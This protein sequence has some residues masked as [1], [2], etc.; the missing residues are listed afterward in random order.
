MSS[1]PENKPTLDRSTLLPILLGVFSLFGILLVFAIGRL[2]SGGN[3][4]PPEDT[5][6][7]FKYQLIGTEPGVSTAELTGEPGSSA[8]PLDG[9]EVPS[10]GS[11]GLVVTAQQGSSS[12]SGSSTNDNSAGTQDPSADEFEETATLTPTDPIIILRTNTKSN[13]TSLPIINRTQ[14]P[15]NTRGPTWTVT[16]S[17][18]K[19]VGPTT[20]EI[21]TIT[22]S[23]TP[24]RTP[25]SIPTGA[26]A[27][28][29]AA[30][31]YDDS[32]PLISY[33]GWTIIT[34][35]SAYQS[36]L[37]VSNTAGSTVI[38][39]FTGQQIRLTFQSSASFGTIRINIGGLNFDLDEANGTNEWVSALLAQGTYTVTIT[40]LT[41][42]S[43]N[44]DSVIIPDFNTPTPTVTAT[45]TGQ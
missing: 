29:L 23:R 32:H 36:T 27:V 30:G 33:N 16:P 5:V 37:H 14:T 15:T 10:P 41:G 25:T 31:T 35:A 1:D 24:S 21:A 26:T 7:P 45:P 2:N 11:S 43:V 28:A 19:N 44:I 34:E 12:G 13:A 42:G 8:V 17:R 20:G 4:L 39:R 40:H 9:S 18:T 6:T 3:A 38:F 22:P